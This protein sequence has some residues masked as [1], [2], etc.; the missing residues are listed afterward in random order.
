MVG[1]PI[2]WLNMVMDV[3]IWRSG[4]KFG[5]SGTKLAE[6]FLAV[7]SGAWKTN[8][9]TAYHLGA[10]RGGG[11]IR[12]ADRRIGET[13]RGPSIHWISHPTAGVP[14]KRGRGR[15]SE[16]IRRSSD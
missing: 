16:M 11:P 8:Q 5:G 1:A 9:R 7:G 12:H 3:K 14:S 13:C 15:W 4:A 10:W 2:P 6:V